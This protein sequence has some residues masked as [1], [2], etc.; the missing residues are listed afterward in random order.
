MHATLSQQDLELQCNQ[1]VLGYKGEGG[2]GAAEH[3]FLPHLESVACICTQEHLRSHVLMY[4]TL[5]QSN[6]LLSVLI[7][8]REGGEESASTPI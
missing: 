7:E 2:G 4:G 1:T 6:F 5:Q 3:V 8:E